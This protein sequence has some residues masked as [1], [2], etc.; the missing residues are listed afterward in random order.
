VDELLD[1]ELGVPDDV[2]D[3]VPDDVLDDVPDDVLDDV[4][5]DEEVEEDVVVDGEVVL[6]AVDELVEVGG[7]EVVAVVV[8][9]VVVV[10]EVGVTL[11]THTSW[12]GRRLSQAWSSQG[13]RATS[14]A[15]V[16]LNRRSIELQSSFGP[17]SYQFEQGGVGTGN[18]EVVVVDA[19]GKG[20]YRARQ[21][22]SPG[23]RFVHPLLISAKGFSACRIPT[24]A[25]DE[26]PR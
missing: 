16:R 19:G 12:L 1:E 4:L 24:E 10:V 14:C 8:L 25:A 20:V 22:P 3:D 11:L 26:A 18:A 17:A 13:F 7:G 9:V 6:L 21:R 15:K 5:E 23:C 2:L